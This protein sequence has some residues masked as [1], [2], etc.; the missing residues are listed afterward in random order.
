[1]AFERFLARVGV[2]ALVMLTSSVSLAEPSAPEKARARSLMDEGDRF[3]AARSYAEALERYE[4]AD[5][6]MQVPTTGIE[7]AR[8]RALL[9][10]FVAAREAALVAAR[11]PKQ[12]SEPAVWDEARTEAA[13]LAGTYADQIG[14]VVLDGSR[15]P[16][17]TIVTIDGAV[18]DVT[19]AEPVSLDPGVH[20]ARMS[21]AGNSSVERRITVEPGKTLRVELAEPHASSP[22]RIPMYAGFGVAG[23]GVL[24]GT[25][26]GAISLSNASTA[27]S[28]CS[29]G[30]CP[31]SAQGDIDGASTFGL[32]SDVGFGLAIAGAALGGVSL[33]LDQK[34]TS[35]ARSGLQ[36]HAFVGLNGA[37]I[38][39]VLP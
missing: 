2:L 8:T 26:F 36:T 20:V 11:L 9:G 27:K 24:T 3:V 17:S 29:G 14:S 39:G 6:I 10:R 4:R 31:R 21:V 15:L 12:P 5:E 35:A 19:S 22:Y 33:Y 37:G 18:V 16:S 28:A 32:A 13:V 25:L 23:L 34:G 30:H 1:V 38:A 7:V